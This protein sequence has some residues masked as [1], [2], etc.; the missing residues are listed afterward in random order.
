MSTGD[1]DDKLGP[2][3]ELERLRKEYPELD[4]Y[5]DLA[6]YKIAF[7]TIPYGAGISQNG[8]TVYIH[9]NLQL[10]L[11]GVDIRDALATHE[12][13]EWALRRFCKI[14]MDYQTDPT[15]HRLA[16]RA[17]YV[18]VEGLLGSDQVDY[19]DAWA[20]YDD[21]L[22]PQLEAIQKLPLTSVPKDLAMYPYEGTEW[23]EKLKEAQS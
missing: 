7:A 5:L 21:F 22:D 6:D 17:E 19:G 2:W 13:T 23:E 18:V 11:D 8:F 15:G 12:R 4:E 3:G 10:D 1:I 20:A 9:P 14:G 16:N